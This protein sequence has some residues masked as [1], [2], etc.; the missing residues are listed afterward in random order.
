MKMN[1][2]KQFIMRFLIGMPIGLLICYFITLFISIGVGDGN[3]YPVQTEL[4]NLCKSQLNAVIVQTIAGM[5]YGGMWGGASVIWEVDSWSL[6]RQ[7][8]THL[9][10]ISVISF[11]IAY[12]MRWMIA[13]SRHKS[14]KSTAK[15]IRDT[16]NRRSLF[17]KTVCNVKKHIMPERKFFKIES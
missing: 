16:A 17:V 11:P 10:V 6:T 2:K 7:T 5:I 12:V 15:S 3:F 1:L 13:K 4:T 14:N 9:I 8:V